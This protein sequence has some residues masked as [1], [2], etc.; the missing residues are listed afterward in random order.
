MP[1]DDRLEA[2][3]TIARGIAAG[4]PAERAVFGLTASFSGSLCVART[5]TYV[6]QRRR[7]NPQFRSMVRRV[8]R[9][10]PSTGPRVHHFVPGIGLVLLTGAAAIVSR[11]DGRELVLSIPFGTGA[12]LILDE[13]GHLVERDDPTGATNASC[14]RRRRAPRRWRPA[15][16]CAS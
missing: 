9:A 5:V 14:S 7:S 12:A 16:V 6:M 1:T 4:S 11:E 3:S 8:R 15:S 13:I 10:G 2:S